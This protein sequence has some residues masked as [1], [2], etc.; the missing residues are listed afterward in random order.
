[1]AGSFGIEK[2]P[3]DFAPTDGEITSAAAGPSEKIF[4]QSIRVRVPRTE[5]APAKFAKR[6]FYD[7]RSGAIQCL[8]GLLD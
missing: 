8:G 4:G 5:R 3:Q 7:L 6:E 1:M 2:F